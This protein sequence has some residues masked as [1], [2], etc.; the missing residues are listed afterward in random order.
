M[1]YL[2]LSTLFAVSVAFALSLGAA[3]RPAEAGKACKR[4][5]LKS[6]CLRSSDQK[7]TLK[8]GRSGNDGDF[9]VRAAD[10]SLG[11]KLDGDTGTA[12][13]S[14]AGDGLVKAWARIN[15]DGTVHECYRCNKDP[16]ETQRLATGRYEV[17]FTPLS[18]DIRSRPRT[19]AGDRR[20]DPKFATVIFPD[21]ILMDQDG[22]IA[23]S[24]DPSSVLVVIVPQGG[25]D[26]TPFTVVIY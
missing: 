6:P 1:R 11:V 2:K 13:N 3:P 12:S 23:G 15:A 26:V 10:K 16:D 17:D 14:F 20:D 7:P 9:T 22:T 5:G 19:L 18:T 24:A 4:I 8:L 21:F 25:L